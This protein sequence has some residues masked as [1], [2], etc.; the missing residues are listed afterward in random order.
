MNYSAEVLSHY[1]N[2]R[3]VGTLDSQLLNVGTGQVGSKEQGALVRIQIQVRDGHIE[4]ARFKAFG[5]GNT[6]AAASLATEWL[7]G[8][9]L[10]KAAE[11]NSAAFVETLSLPP[12]KM[13]C[14][15]LA[16]DAI[17]AAIK[18]YRNKQQV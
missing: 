1:R 5:C 2:P 14:A 15:M 6:I 11:L 3:N 18:D 13:Y 9:D 16:E 4:Q 7:Q 8:A 12:V 10:D 17:Q